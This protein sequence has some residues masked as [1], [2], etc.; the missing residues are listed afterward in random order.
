[1]ISFIKTQRPDFPWLH[2]IAGE[3]FVSIFCLLLLVFRIK[4][5]YKR[6]DGNIRRYCY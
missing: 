2:L 4:K 6:V 5:L 1:M 3:N